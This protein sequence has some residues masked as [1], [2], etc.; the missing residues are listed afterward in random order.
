MRCVV[1]LALLAWGCGKREQVQS[2]VGSGAGSGAGSATCEPMTFA[3]TVELPEASAATWFEIGGKR[4]L[5][6]V[7]DSGHSGAYA[8]ID[9]ESGSM[10]EKGALPLGKG[11]DDIEGLATRGDY[12][13][14]LTSSGWIREWQRS[15]D[16]KTFELV[17]GPYEIGI[18]GMSCSLDDSNCAKNYEGLALAP[19]LRRNGCVGY[20]CS[21][22]DGHLYCLTVQDRK[23]VVD[24]S[25]SIAVEKKN[26][27]GDCAFSPEGQLYVGNNMFGMSTVYR[28][29]GWQDPAQAKVVMVGELGLG[30]PEVIAVA[31]DVIY[32]MS[33]TGGSPSMMAKFRCS[34]PGR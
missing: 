28:I 26:V 5:V 29:D 6:V 25:R 32:R 31:G 2:G 30:F 11:T 14:G 21:K 19:D 15:R 3:P 8:V 23:L 34:A 12:I 27:L 4:T 22:Q 10:I 16:D 13:V 1:L 20:A 18:H 9:P 24:P 17:E 33:D 7:S